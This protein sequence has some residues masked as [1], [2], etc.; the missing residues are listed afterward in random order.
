MVEVDL[1]QLAQAEGAGS[2]IDKRD[3]VDVELVLEGR[4]PVQLLENGLRAEPR[5]DPD[6]Q[7]QAV[8]AV[9]EVGDVG[10][11]AELL[12][13]D[14][15]LDLLDHLLRADHVGQLRHHEPGLARGDRFDRHPRPG[16]EAAAAGLI[17]VADAREADDRAAGREVWTRHI[18]HELV[19]GRGRIVEQEPGR[20]DDL[21]EVVRCHVRRHAHGDAAR[22]VDEKVRER[23]REH[24]RL[25]QLVVVIRDEVDD[26]LVEVCRHR[27]GGG[28]QARL[29]VP[30]RGGAVVEGAEVAVPVDERDAHDE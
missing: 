2:A 19:E 1:Q 18:G 9:G 10:D 14:A 27:T 29:G 17:G 8:P 4:V 3:G 12:R 23:G 20:T 16:L 5:F 26:V 25:R 15:V 22:A 21:D 13:P 24:L 30:C 7:A 11:S 28:S 6:D